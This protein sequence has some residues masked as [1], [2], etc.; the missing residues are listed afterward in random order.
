MTDL[1]AFSAIVA[2]LYYLGARAELTRWLWSRYP[3]WIDALAMCP[4]CSGWWIGLVA[5]FVVLPPSPASSW[6]AQHLWAGVYGLVIN[7]I[8]FGAMMWHQSQ[9]DAAAL[10]ASITAKV[11]AFTEGEHASLNHLETEIVGE[12]SG[13]RSG[14]CESIKY[15]RRCT[16]HAGGHRNHVATEGGVPVAA[17]VDDDPVGGDM[18]T[19]EGRAVAVMAMP[20]CPLCGARESEPCASG[21]HGLKPSSRVLSGIAG[22]P[23]PACKH[24]GA[25]IGVRCVPGCEGSAPPIRLRRLPTPPSSD[26][27]H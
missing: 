11:P 23:L 24:C 4:R 1:L 5:G 8:V 13:T 20:P 26:S 7:P 2:F 12:P 21:C 17:W 22:T 18:I 27:T 14:Q 16:L 10:A 19:V 3:K 6:W 25:G 9:E 15:G